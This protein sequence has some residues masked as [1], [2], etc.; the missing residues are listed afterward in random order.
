MSRTIDRIVFTGDILRPSI[1]AL[2]PTQHENIY[3]LTQLLDAPIR[4]ATDIPREIVHWDNA[5]CNRARLDSATIRALYAAFGLDPTIES[6][7]RI[8]SA[9]TLPDPVEHLF[10]T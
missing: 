6:W 5:W 2:R 4:L 10:E 1:G 8:F 9:E 3:W 7:A